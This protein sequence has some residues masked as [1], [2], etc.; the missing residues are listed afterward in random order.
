MRTQIAVIDYGSQYSQLIV[1]RLRAL[2]WA[3]RV[4]FADGIAATTDWYRDN[5]AWWQAVRSGEWDDYYARQY[6]WRLAGS[7]PG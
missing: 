7:S 2:G 4:A 1:R 5:P 6:G 3:P